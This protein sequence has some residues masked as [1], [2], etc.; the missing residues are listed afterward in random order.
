MKLFG[1]SR[2]SKFFLKTKKSKSQKVVD[3]SGRSSLGLTEF[4]ETISE[5]S[6]IETSSDAWS[7]A[8]ALDQEGRLVDF[9]SRSTRRLSDVSSRSRRGSRPS[10]AKVA[11]TQ[12]AKKAVKAT[13]Q[14]LYGP[15]PESLPVPFISEDESTP[16][17]EILDRCES[18]LDLKGICDYR[19]K[20]TPDEWVPRDGR[21]IRL[22]GRH[23]LNVEP[24]IALLRKFRF[25]TPPNLHYVR[26]HGICPQ[27]TWED[28]T[29]IVG[30]E[31]FMPIEIRMDDLI[32][33]GEPREI[34]VTLTCAGNR[35]KEQNTIRQTIGFNWGPCATST[36]V[37]KGIL[38]RDVLK[39]VGVSE[40]DTEGLHVEFLGY[41]DLPNKI[42][43]GPFED[44]PWG[45]TEKFGTS[46][47]LA[48][49]MN[50]AYD[51]MIAY[52]QNGER[53]H[54]DHGYPIRLIVPGYAAARNIKW[55]K[56]INIIPHETKNHYFYHDNRIIPPHVQTMEE[57][58]KGDWFY[59]PEYVFNELNIN[60]VIASPGHGE[61][62]SL[63]EGLGK[64]YT[65]SGYAYTGGGRNVTRV[66]ISLD[67]GNTWHLAKLDKK[68][69]PTEYG[70]SWCWT[71]WDYDVTVQQ[72]INA[73]EIRCRAWDSSNN[74]QPEE[75]IWSL[76]GYGELTILIH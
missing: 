70:M 68:E 4:S 44:A 65:I 11:R 58:M 23:P 15:Y 50:P 41:E 49:A 1:S 40:K 3:S 16:P 7:L 43:P 5:D 13:A 17:K 37:W 62:I 42:G 52:E 22:T 59:K 6:P 48:R 74:R 47:P 9:S 14:E 35:R 66:D 60:S 38:V 32:S 19:D 24:P 33:L 63:V 54:P 64:T 51:I 56:Q 53:L 72:F 39:A 73:S 34:P 29:L 71:W 26:S 61:K 21:L 75:P 25:I 46:I 27:L 55:L 31:V 18:Y 12:K 67:G 76:M 28:H 36:S 8:F 45:E 69:K 57:A 30:G 20:G 2:L 10:I